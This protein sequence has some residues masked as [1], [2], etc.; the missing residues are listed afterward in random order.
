MSEADGKK[1]SGGAAAAAAA[2]A[3]AAG[4]A[5]SVE[6]LANALKREQANGQ[7]LLAEVIALENEIVNRT[8]ADFEK[9]ISDET[10]EFWREELV[11]NRAKAMVLLA[12]LKRA[13]LGED[14]D[15]GTRR[16]IHNRATA[17][18]VPPAVVGGA[19][20]GAVDGRAVKIRNRAHEIA[21]AEG[22][23]FSVAFG[24]AEREAGA[25]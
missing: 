16:P 7:A 15:S 23:A 5:G 11:S 10:R 12:E 8:M 2:A 18:P 22:L 19:G 20:A 24:R 6:G 25:Q 9:V 21:K 4:A 13:K 17:R 14:G 1:G 3:G